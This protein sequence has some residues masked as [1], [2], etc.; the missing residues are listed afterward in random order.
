MNVAFITTI[1]VNLGVLLLASWILG[2]VIFVR[3][4]KE[5]NALEAALLSAREK[6]KKSRQKQPSKPASP[7][8]EYPLEPVILENEEQESLYL[9]DAIDTLSNDLK[10]KEHR[11]STLAN[12]HSQQQTTMEGWQDD[13]SETAM[14]SQII[15]NMM[16]NHRESQN[17]IDSLQEDLQSNQQTIQQLEN[18]LREG[19]DKDGRIA[20]LEETENRLRDRLNQFNTNKEQ[21]TVLADGLRKAN[22]KNHK[23]S[24]DNDKLKRNMKQLA[25]ASKEQLATIND[26]STEL[27]KANKLEQYQRNIIS[28]L[29]IKLHQEKSSN[30]DS[31]KITEL[32]QELQKTNQI[33]K[34]TLEEKEQIESHLLEMDKALENSKQT[35]EALERAR[36]EIET[37]EMYFPEFEPDSEEDNAVSANKDVHQPLP[38]LAITEEENPELFNVINDNRL[39]GILQEFWMTLDT[40]PLQLLEEKNVSRPKTLVSWVKTSIHNDE[41]FVTIG[42]S[43]ALAEALAKA[44]FSSTDKSMDGN[45]IQDALGE[46]GNVLAGT[47][48]NEL[49][50]EYI[51]GISQY[52]DSSSKEAHLEGVNIAA[53][54][55]MSANEQPLYIALVKP[56][57]DNT[58]HENIDR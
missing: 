10:Q 17:I 37:L 30:N 25:N 23:L 49:N 35:E 12:L 31:G 20:I 18:K 33:L 55:L 52:L 14:S 54:I 40:P 45:D 48:A 1:A 50:P 32:E 51:V 58:S 47:L 9:L 6:L 5:R 22:D 11:L 29:E 21:A 7:T 19:Q 16:D 39:F 8:P 43:Q 56:D 42:T 46:L 38:Q 53:E 27:E 41:F 34:R 57:S 26:I 4:I 3:L 24:Q 28:N 15:N 44:M 13:P 2:L 36:K